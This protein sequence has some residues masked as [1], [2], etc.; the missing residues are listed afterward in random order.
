MAGR[1]GAPAGRDEMRKRDREKTEERRSS[2]EVRSRRA[3]GGEESRER[4]GGVRDVPV[5]RRVCGRSG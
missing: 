1:V 5:A 2:R 3:E 4:E